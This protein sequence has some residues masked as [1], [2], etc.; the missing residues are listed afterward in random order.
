MFDVRRRPWYIQGSSSPKNVLLLIDTS[1]STSGQTI[2]LMKVT[3]NSILDTLVEDDFVLAMEF[4]A[5]TR[6]VGCPFDGEDEF[7]HEQFEEAG[8]CFN[9]FKQADD[10]NKKAI[11]AA[12]SVLKSQNQANYQIGFKAAFEQF[13]KFRQT[14]ASM[15]QGSDCNEVIM[16][17]TDGGMEY[18]EAIFKEYNPKKTVR[19]FTFAIGPAATPIAAPRRIACTNRG[20]FTKIPSMGAIRS[21]VQNM[22]MITTVTLPVYNVS[23]ASDNSDDSS[24]DGTRREH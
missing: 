2:G 24:G 5:Y 14:E 15:S 16:L 21:K 17:L 20:Y 3:V 8:C 6:F 9:T 7:T 1:G 4:N 18:P 13:I 23:Y 19:I 11:S 12:V 22:G 10:R